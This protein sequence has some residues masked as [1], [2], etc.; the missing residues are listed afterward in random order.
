MHFK[1]MISSKDCS[2]PL[3]RKE[4]NPQQRIFII[5]P[6]IFSQNC[7]A[8]R[9]VHQILTLLQLILHPVQLRT[10]CRKTKILKEIR[11]L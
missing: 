8:R 6:M 11:S 3:H 10:S 4:L 2:F 1:F 5:I 7:E 9:R